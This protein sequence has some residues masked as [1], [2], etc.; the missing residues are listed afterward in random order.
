MARW[1]AATLVVA[2]LGVSAAF[3][4]SPETADAVDTTRVLGRYRLKLKGDGFDRE[5]ASLSYRNK[6]LRGNATLTLVRPESAV[7]AREVI[8]RIVLDRRLDGSV[9]D[10]A[11]PDPAFLGK[12][13]LIEDSLTV[14]GTGSANFVNAVTLR[15]KN[16]GRK[17]SGWWLASFPAAA[18]DGGFAGGVGVQIAGRLQLAQPS[19]APV[20]VDP[21]PV[22]ADVNG[23]RKL[24]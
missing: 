11:T 13:L 9:L 21:L 6:K 14:I 5:A 17:L 16:K 18:V 19:P 23:N 8:V 20:P 12:G 1:L 3:V 10:R 4:V 15:F 24:R 22:L 7:S 2:A